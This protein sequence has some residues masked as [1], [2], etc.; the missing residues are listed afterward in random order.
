MEKIWTEERSEVLLRRYLPVARTRV[1]DTVSEAVSAA[2]SYPVVV[3]LSSPAIV[4]KTDVHGVRI[5]HTQEELRAA[6]KALFAVAAKNKAGDARFL[7]QDFVKGTEMI[8]GLQKDPTFGHVVMLGFGGVMVE[9]F[10]DVSFRVCPITTHEAYSMMDDLQAKQLLE[11]VRGEKPRDTK[12]LAKVLVKV[13][14][15]PKKYPQI[16]SLDINPFIL[17]DK[18]GYVVDARIV[19]E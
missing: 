18:G 19:W 3:K 16:S 15:L 4:H 10:K 1:V 9:V 12:L 6:C 11:G 13:G 7:L 17:K 8:I 14:N 2:K 5:V